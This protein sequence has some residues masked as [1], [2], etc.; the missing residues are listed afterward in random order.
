MSSILE[1]L[2]RQYE[3]FKLMLESILAMLDTR[4]IVER[5]MGTILALFPQTTFAVQ[6]WFDNAYTN[7]TYFL[8]Y[9]GM[10][11]YFINLPVLMA[12]LLYIAH[13][14]FALLGLRL[15]RMVRSVVT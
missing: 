2:R 6:G 14:E 11:G 1:F 15:W 9:M 5:L 13:T 4:A 3:N 7:M 12:V 10:A 8:P